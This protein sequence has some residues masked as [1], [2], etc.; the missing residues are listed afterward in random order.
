MCLKM[1][2]K[3]LEV[4]CVCPFFPKEPRVFLKLKLKLNNIIVGGFNPF[5]KYALQIESFPQ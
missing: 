5:K 3:I 2:T 1:E 4:V